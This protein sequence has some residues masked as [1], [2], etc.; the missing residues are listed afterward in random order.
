MKVLKTLMIA[1]AFVAGM[2]GTSSA[3]PILVQSGVWGGHLYEVFIDETSTWNQAKDAAASAGGY[4]ATITSAEEQSYIASLV[5]PYLSA[6][7]GDAGFKLGGFQP[8]GSTEAGGGWR[9][10]TSEAWGY[11][12]WGSGE[13]NNVGGNESYLYLDERFNWKWNDYNDIDAFYNP[14]G[15]IVETVPE[16]STVLL[17]GLGLGGFALWRRR[18]S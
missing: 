14:S 13:P 11:A 15:Y 10:V 4:L 3:A 2:V 17:L 1:G 8:A 6:N 12:N 18:S 5:S 16:P 9:W 7:G